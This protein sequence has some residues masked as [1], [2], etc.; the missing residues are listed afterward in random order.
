MP[1]ISFPPEDRSR[2][3]FYR[4]MI[5]CIQ[6]R[7]IALVSSMSPKGEP[8]VAPFSFFMGVGSDPPA[9]A[10]SV[11]TP[12]DP[13]TR[14]DTL[15]NIEATGQ[16]VVAAVTEQNV[17][18][19]S[20][21][22]WEYPHGV[23]EFEAAGL[24]S[25][26]A[27]RVLPL[28]VGDSPVNFECELLQVVRTGDRAGSG[29]IIVGRIVFAHLDASVLTPDQRRADPGLLALVG[30]MGGE[31]YC[32]TREIIRIPRPTSPNPTGGPTP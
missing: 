19:V 31:D 8:N 11:A 6:P 14:K 30:R 24:A 17:H 2:A 13:G 21:A 27:T 5:D 22:S 9:L 7:P 3:D 29:N 1:R 10:F 16:F 32:L 28:C 15:A 12:R 26:P 25:F 20:Q 18:R 23:S 4:L